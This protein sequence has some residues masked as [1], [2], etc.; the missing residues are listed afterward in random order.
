MTSRPSALA[1]AAGLWIVVGIGA[2]GPAHAVAATS[3]RVR[4]LAARAVTDD[5]ALERLKEIDSV[6]GRPIDLDALLEARGSDLEARLRALASD[7]TDRAPPEPAEA[8]RSA[9]AILEERRF[10]S[11]DLPR[12]FEGIFDRIGSWLKDLGE[13][14]AGLFET[15]GRFD[16]GAAALIGTV[17]LVAAALLSSLLVRRRSTAAARTSN[18]VAEDA[19]RSP[20]AL[21][22]DADAAERAGEFN[23]A[24][25]LRFAAGLLRLHRAGAIA[26]R[27]SLTSGEIALQLGSRYFDE[28]A[29]TFDRVVY[30]HH[31][32][33]PEDVHTSRAAWE[34]VLTERRAA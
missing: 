30:G 33:S 12:P 17:A 23:K 1:A 4:E 26:L 10:R 25:R 13:S 20:L 2:A 28:L 16:P 18:A 5:A 7:G 21:E 31:R 8:R 32:C 6:D 22:A 27:P 11:T 15:D 19:T 3:E 14:I 24:L 29:A 34:R 9:G